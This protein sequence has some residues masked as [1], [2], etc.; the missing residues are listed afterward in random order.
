M[1]IKLDKSESNN[2]YGE[3]LAVMSNYLKLV[4]NPKKKIRG[5]NTEAILLTGIALVFLVIFTVLYLLDPSYT[6]FQYVIII[7]S[8]ALFFGIIY[9]ILIHRRISKLKNNDSDRK[10]IIED[11]YVEMNIG[12]EQFRL[13]FNDIQWI[14]L[15]KYSITFLPKNKGAVLIAIEIK[16]ASQVIDNIKDKSIIVDNSNL[17]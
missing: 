7:F 12:D 8:I 9:N 3:V 13:N 16:Y 15:N 14:I 11:D 17:Y 10:L 4:K 6:P 1:E 5:T 2:Y